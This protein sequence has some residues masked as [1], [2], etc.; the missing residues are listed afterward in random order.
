VTA[1][2]RD[3]YTLFRQGQELISG[4]HWAQAVVPLEKARKLEP[5]KTSIR[6][7]LGRAY[8]RSG[9]YKRAARE[10]EAVV[11]LA[12]TND[13]AHF[14]LGRSLQKLGQRTAASRHFT[15]A[16][17]LRPNRSDY[18]RYRERLRAA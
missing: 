11:E 4:Q 16:C 12:P 2:D 1:G 3:A 17:G 7:A 14:C 9:R 8:F 6:E 18:Q 13:F 15:L 10:F 5:N